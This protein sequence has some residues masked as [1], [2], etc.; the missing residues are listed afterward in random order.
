METVTLIIT[1][2]EAELFKHFQKRHAFMELM[3][4]VGAFKPDMARGSIV[5]HYDNLCGIASVDVNKH[6]AVDMGKR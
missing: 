1:N 4:S 6:Y 2:Q 3:E 5:I